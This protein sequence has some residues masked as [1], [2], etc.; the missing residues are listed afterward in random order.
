MKSNHERKQWIDFLR[1]LAMLLVIWGHIAEGQRGFILA[2]GPFKLP[3][4][5]AITG[6]L[7]NDRDGDVRQFGKT[8]LL[9]LI[10]PW[11]LLS[12]VWIKAPYALITGKPQQAWNAL[13]AILSGRE[14][15]FM[16]CCILAEVIQFLLRKFLR[17][18]IP[19][20]AASALIAVLGL[21]LTRWGISF[22]LVDVACTAQIWMLFGALFRTHEDWIAE[23]AKVPVLAGLTALYIALI[24]LSAHLFPGATVDVHHNEYFNLP[25]C[26]LLTAI[27]LLVL[28]AAARRIPR[29][30]RWVV[31]VGQNTLPFYILHYTVRQVLARGLGLLHLSLPAGWP[32]FLIEMVI[33]CAVMSAVSLLLNRYLPFA[34]GR[35]SRRKAAAAG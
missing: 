20:A 8:L 4:F 3:L 32:G 34:V 33:V 18:E 22:A 2:T 16:P 26:L 5:F 7:F 6:Y 25:L 28:F 12:L 35:K 9:R 15:W 17:R 21:F 24:I 10:L 23:R 30:P 11:L 14:I 13:Y 31:F 1:G 29:F 19:R 27:S